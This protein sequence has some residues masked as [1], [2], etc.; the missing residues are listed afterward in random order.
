MRKRIL[1]LGTDLMMDTKK[2]IKALKSQ[3]KQQIT[4]LEDTWAKKLSEK[5]EMM[6]HQ[7]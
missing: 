6:Q 2:K 3:G 1:I 4:S 5:L 7:L